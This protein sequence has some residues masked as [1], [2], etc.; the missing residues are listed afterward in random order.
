MCLGSQD[1]YLYR[2]SKIRF[3][4]IGER[5]KRRS[6]NAMRGRPEML[7]VFCKSELLNGQLY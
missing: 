2:Y 4:V 6:G 5:F 1:G 7:S 3:T